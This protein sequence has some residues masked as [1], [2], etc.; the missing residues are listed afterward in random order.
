MLSVGMILFYLI[1]ANVKCH[2]LNL[3]ISNGIAWNH[4]WTKMYL[5]DTIPQLIY[6]FDFDEETGNISNKQIAIDMKNE[7]YVKPLPHT[8]RSLDLKSHHECIIP[9]GMCMD[10]EGK[11][12]I[13]EHNGG[14]VGRWDPETGQLLTKISIPAKKVTACCFG[15][16]EY[17]T[18]YVTTASVYSSDEDWQLYPHA[19]SIFAVSNLG[20]KG[21]PVQFF[22]DSKFAH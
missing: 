22:D 2:K 20:V 18:L 10:N 5:V 13:A 4:D 12:W 1:L 19:G 16:P 9:D 15:G 11:L 3:S 14:C 7:D 21:L 8:E 17:N 6:S